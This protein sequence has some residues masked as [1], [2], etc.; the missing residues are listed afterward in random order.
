MILA[1]VAMAWAIRRPRPDVLMQLAD[2][3]LGLKERLST[4]WERRAKNGAMDALL[5]QDALH[6]ADRDIL[7]RAFPVRVNRGELGGLAAV[8]AAALALA[9]LP[10]ALDQVLARGPAH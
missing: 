6:H 7:Q 3:R 9:A 5:R 10:K 1:L 2:V 8:A 4:A